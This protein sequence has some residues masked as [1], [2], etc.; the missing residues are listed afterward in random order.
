MYRKYVIRDENM[1]KGTGFSF[2]IFSTFDMETPPVKSLVFLVEN[3]SNPLL[4]DDLEKMKTLII[5]DCTKL[6]EEM[7]DMDVEGRSERA[8]QFYQDWEVK[9]KRTSLQSLTDLSDEL[10]DQLV[11]T[12]IDAKFSED[13]EDIVQDKVFIDKVKCLENMTKLEDAHYCP[14]EDVI[15]ECTKGSIFL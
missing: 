3:Y 15:K 7:K 9:A 12:M 4:I 6:I 1:L 11:R 8:Q 10:E 14:E 2:P 13:S 5:E